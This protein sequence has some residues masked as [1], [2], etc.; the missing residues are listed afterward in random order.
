M[1][2][3][4]PPAVVAGAAPVGTATYPVPVGALFVSPS[5]NDSAAGTIGAPKRTLGAAISA[6]SSGATIVLRAGEYHEEVTVPSSKTLTI[7]NYP[8]EAAWFD[9]SK[10][11]PAWSGSGP[12]SAPL[13]V[14]WS[15]ISSSRYGQEGDGLANLPEQVWVDDAALRQVADGAT[16]GPGQF[17]VNRSAGTITIGTDPTGRVVRVAELRRPL[18]VT[19]PV[20]LQGFGVR[21]YSPAMVEGTD[22]A[23]I[24]VAGSA[25]NCVLRDMVF[26][27]SGMHGMSLVRPI[28]LDKVTVEDCNNAG[29][30]ITTGN[31]SRISRFLIR[32][33]NRGVWQRE[34]ITAGVK[35][36]RTDDIILRDGI[37]DDVHGAFG[38]WFDVSCTGFIVANVTVNDTD[39]A[40]ETELSGGGF[41]SGVQHHAW[42]VNCR[43]TNTV[44]WP[45]KVF[46]SDYVTVANCDLD[47]ARVPINVQQDERYNTGQPGNLTFG[48]VPWVCR[49]NRLWNNR[50]VGQPAVASMIAYHDPATPVP[51][52]DGGPS[53]VLLGWHFFD[54]VAGNWVPEVP[55][56]SMIQLGRVDGARSS[57]NTWAAAAASTSTVGGP[58]GS[59]LGA[60]HSG[61]SAPSDAIA[62]PLPDDIADLLGVPHGHQQVGAIL[63]APVP[64]DAAPEEEEEPPVPRQWLF[65]NSDGVTCTTG[66]VVAVDG[67]AASIVN[68]PDTAT[69]QFES[70]FAHAGA[71]GVKFTPGTGTNQ[72]RLPFA[73]SSNT[74]EVS[75]YH[76]A[77]SLPPG[78]RDIFNLR[79]SSGQIIRLAVDGSGRLL[80]RTSAG[81]AIAQT[82]TGVWVASRQ[83]RIEIVFNVGGS[84][85]TDSYT[86]AIFD[87]D[88]TTP[89][90]TLSSSS[91][92][93]GTAAA[94]HIDIGHP[95]NSSSAW[96]TYYDS[97]QMDTGPGTTFIGPYLTG[98]T[99]TLSATVPVVTGAASGT[100]TVAGTLATVTPRASATATG[101][102][103]VAGTL[104]ASTPR[105]TASMAGT[106]T[107]PGTMGASVPRAT[108]TTSGTLTV[109]GTTSGAVPGRTGTLSG[110]VT[111][112]GT[113][114]GGVPLLTATMS[115]AT[116][117]IDR[118]RDVPWTLTID[119]DWRTAIVSAPVLTLEV[120]TGTARTLDVAAAGRSLELDAPQETLELSAPARTLEMDT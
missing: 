36:T 64:V 11:Y 46:D 54:E 87:G 98:T 51:D 50:V 53:A 99:G 27:E 70:D 13:G 65:D 18:L 104:T 23:L 107:V 103:T 69:I 29:I 100:V 14:S 115:G 119:S 102:V 106:V 43:S 95:N 63:A 61:T 32:R 26:R 86:A 96:T 111:V 34:P 20:T 8:G 77:A 117:T 108:A 30:Q 12:W 118:D 47:A 5:G 116:V 52:P 67:A 25:Y 15:P 48:V 81:A 94:T 10:V 42:F 6:A 2:W 17:S 112:T 83:N 60:N 45:V 91:I 1:V 31:G 9:G 97:I 33:C 101:T 35:V 40:F 120:D 4:P 73:S 88:S 41:F 78:T 21:R 114:T 55:P 76:T 85:A 57:F 19:G 38:V 68:A 92:N 56:G 7:Q 58:P 89:L 113:T 72:I 24:Y 82:S 110:T 66:N 62:V 90:A 37:V 84:G 80:S 79:H 109:G 71:T 59:R 49:H 22:S 75:F 74:G 93:L 3:E 44:D 16:P 39:I 28:T 105:V